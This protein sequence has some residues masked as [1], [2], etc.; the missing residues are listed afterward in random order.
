MSKVKKTNVE[1]L[2]KLQQ[3]M[4]RDKLRERELK[5]RIAGEQRKKRNHT[6]ILI[7]AEML[8]FYD[9]QTEQILIDGDDD[10]VKNW[11]HDEMKKIHYQYN[12]GFQS[13]DEMY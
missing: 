4:N 9:A 5:N 7:A 11:V 12:D 10:F 3:R 1:M 2:E 13:G 6:L 8:K